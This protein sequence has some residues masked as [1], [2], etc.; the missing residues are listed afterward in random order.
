LEIAFCQT[1]TR[2]TGSGGRHRR[3]TNWQNV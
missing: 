2:E 3:Q 1:V